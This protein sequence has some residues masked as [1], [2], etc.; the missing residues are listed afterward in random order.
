MDRRRFLTQLAAWGVGCV[1][2]RRGTGKPPRLTADELREKMRRALRN[3]KFRPPL[4]PGVGGPYVIYTTPEALS[5]LEELF[6]DGRR[7]TTER[8]D[9]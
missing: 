4:P 7:E 1:L 5:K 2:S 8:I 9:A 6:A 3:T